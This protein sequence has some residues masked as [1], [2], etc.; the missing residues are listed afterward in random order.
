MTMVVGCRGGCDLTA[1]WTEGRSAPECGRFVIDGL[2]DREGLFLELDC[3]DAGTRLMVGWILL[4]LLGLGF[5]WVGVC[6]VVL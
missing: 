6:V 1:D 5:A 3:R 4:D 2:E